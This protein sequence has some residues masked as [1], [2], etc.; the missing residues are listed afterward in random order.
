[1]GLKD[2]P[3][4]QDSSIWGP[5]FRPHCPHPRGS[6]AQPH[7]GG[8]GAPPRPPA[9]SAVKVRSGSTRPL[10]QAAGDRWGAIPPG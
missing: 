8:G 7:V 9:E 2:V 4:Q 6:K 3:G 10:F 1:M 5:P